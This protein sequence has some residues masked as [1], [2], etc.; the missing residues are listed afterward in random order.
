MSKTKLLSNLNKKVVASGIPLYKLAAITGVSASAAYKLL[1]GEAS[2][3]PNAYAKIIDALE[4]KISHA[5]FLKSVEAKRKS[6]GISVVE[7]SERVGFSYATLYRLR[8]G[9]ILST[10]AYCKIAKK[11]DLPLEKLIEW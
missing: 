9:T 10:K 8:Q 11:L 2:P 5:L 3:T 4:L 6:L 7:L 1:N